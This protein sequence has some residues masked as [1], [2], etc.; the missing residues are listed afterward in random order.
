MKTKLFYLII[1]ATMLLAACSGGATASASTS[2]PRGHAC[3]IFDERRRTGI[4]IS[5]QQPLDR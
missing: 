4:R 5:R 1:V 2:K 3:D